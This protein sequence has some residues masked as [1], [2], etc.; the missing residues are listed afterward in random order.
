MRTNR[1]IATVRTG[2]TAP[3]P[4]WERDRLFVEPVYADDKPYDQPA[5]GGRIEDEDDGQDAA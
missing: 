5:A 2:P 1:P 3:I 4:L